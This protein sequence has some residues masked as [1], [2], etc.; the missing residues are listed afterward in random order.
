M[1]NP[2]IEKLFSI[3]NQEIKLKPDYITCVQTIQTI[4]NNIL[5][6][7]NDVKKRKIKKSN[8]KFYETVGR[9]QSA[10]QIL[11]YVI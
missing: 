1:N 8:K 9:Y 10:L 7:P 3:L 2:E 11:Y 5:I 4:L 6:D